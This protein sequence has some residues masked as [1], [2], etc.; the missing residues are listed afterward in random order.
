[1]LKEIKKELKKLIDKEANEASLFQV[2]YFLMDC[3]VVLS[4]EKG[5]FFEIE[6]YHKLN[7]LKFFNML[8]DNT[9]LLTKTAI[10][11]NKKSNILNL[12]KM[13]ETDIIALKDKVISTKIVDKYIVNKDKIIVELA[14]YKFWDY[15]LK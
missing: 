13:A 14:N 10:I 3:N 7:D 15:I 6:K 9:D 4:G 1:M 8:V 2:Y 12:E 5:I 11:D